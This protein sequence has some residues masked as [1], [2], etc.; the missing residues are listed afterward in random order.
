MQIH[1]K[2][3][4]KRPA[5]LLVLLSGVASVPLR[6]QGAALV[7]DINVSGAAGF[8]SSQPNDFLTVGNQIFFLANAANT[9]AGGG[10]VTQVAVT[11][12]T[13]TGT[14]FL[15]APCADSTSCGTQPALIA[16]SGN[17]D[18]GSTGGAGELLF[19][20]TEIDVFSYLLWRSDGTRAGTFPLTT[21][22][23]RLDAAGDQPGAYAR[24]G[25]ELYF[26]GCDSFES[27]CGLWKSDG[28]VAGTGKVADLDD[29]SPV[30]LTLLGRKIFFF[31][32]S[33]VDLTALWVSDGTGGGT[34]PLVVD[35]SAP[36]GLLTAATG[37]VFF[38]GDD[39]HGGRELWTSDGTVAGTQALTSFE[40]PSPFVSA[41]LPVGGSIY[42]AADDVTH[43]AEIWTSDGTPA[44]TRRVTEFGYDQPLASPVRMAVLGQQLLFLATDG[45]H[46]TQ[47]WSTTGTLAST[48]PVAPVPAEAGVL[49]PAGA[50]HLLF[51]SDDAHG[52]GQLWTTDGTAGGTVPLLPGCPGNG[53][54]SLSV[55]PFALGGAAFFVQNDA[56][57][58]PFLWRTD[59]TAAGTHRW[60][61]ATVQPTFLSFFA[62]VPG[63]ATLGGRVFY[64]GT[65]DTGDDEIWSSDGQSG[66]THLVSDLLRQAPGSAPASL[67]AVGNEI[68]FTATDGVQASLWRSTGTAD[69]TQPLAASTQTLAAASGLLFFTESSA[70]GAFH[71]W[72][73]DGT[74]AGTRELPGSPGAKLSDGAFVAYRG[75]LAYALA[76]GGAVEI[77]QSDGT[78]SGTGLLLALPAEVTAVEHFTALDDELYFVATDAQGVQTLWRSDGNPAN[79]AGTRQISQPFPANDV[80]PHFVRLGPWV[81]FLQFN[82][83]VL[84]AVW[85]TDGTPEGTV[86]VY[87]SDY[88]YGGTLNITDPVA[89]GGALY[90]FAPT[91]PTHRGLWRTDGTAGGTALVLELGK[92]DEDIFGPYLPAFPTVVGNL[93]F[94]V[95]DDGVHG[96]E[97]WKS[98][99]ST[100]GTVL[101][102]DL[103]PGFLA[104]NPSDLTAVAGRLYF[105]AD[106]GVHG[107]ELWQ[108]DGTATGT[109]LVADVAPGAEGSS[110]SGL[111]ATT[112]RLYWSADDGLHG[113]ELWSLPLSGPTGCQPGDT[114]LCIAGNRF[115]VEI[116][117]KDFQGNTGVGHAVPLTSDT[118]YFW[119]FAPTN[120]EAIVKVLDARALNQAFWVFYGALSNVEYTMTVT[121]TQTGLTRRYFNPAGQL[122][123]VGDTAGFGPLGSYAS[124]TPAAPASDFSLAST[125]V[126][127][128]T[129][130]RAATG[131]CAPGPKRLCLQGNRFAVTAAWTDFQGKTGT[132]TAVS[133]TPDTGYFWFFDPANVEVVTKVLDGTGLNGKFW[134][135]YGALSNVSYMLTVTDTRTGAVKV[136]KN[137]S[138]QFGSVAD[139]GAF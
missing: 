79:P 67:T 121:D 114:R 127:A 138:G 19:F 99:G 87:T 84:F 27:H 83:G 125:L 122:A 109:R 5:L 46:P 33:G 32:D 66:G 93:L 103:L 90:F 92:G 69:S 26:S 49:L 135:F 37:R 47:I 65:D 126:S 94:F 71:L 12:G 30:G 137:P 41:F 115:Q 4:L 36:L 117:W 76:R 116:A 20:T 44:G 24:I 107:R 6:A 130:A 59:G 133:L 86:A 81:F 89:F 82:G 110:P 106:D 17:G 111:T 2:R 112:D 73:T 58:H 9:A 95:G 61:D 57:G 139:T 132:G 35:P 68:F 96:R 72:R 45:L 60:S 124:E 31:T 63:L 50:S 25:K 104:A 75:R 23:L 136:Y 22:A 85:R 48:A 38:V 8:T 7:R 34:L 11:D 51:L 1:M 134:F 105:A 91:S 100:A 98:D 10:V 3:A 74:A 18:S 123:S 64:A 80:D 42:F 55:G 29:G 15:D 39:G 78:A 52:V 118:G 113:R 28:T 70:D 14:Q 131:T 62:T 16:A 40:A 43:G 88:D 119:F 120:V 54:G 108:S 102:R 56:A 101:M 128:R 53:C 97:L 77:W 129:D 21:P 13:P